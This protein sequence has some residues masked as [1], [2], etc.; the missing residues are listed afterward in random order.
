[1]ISFDTCTCGSVVVSDATAVAELKAEADLLREERDEA[2]ILMEKAAKAVEKLKKKTAKQAQV[3]NF[4]EVDLYRLKLSLH[5]FVEAVEGPASHQYVPIALK[6][7]KSL[8][9][10]FNGNGS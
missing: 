5:D 7:A 1:M 6:H 10:S 8:L 3:I 2:T 4:L 9:G